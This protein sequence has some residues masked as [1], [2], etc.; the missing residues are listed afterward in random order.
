MSVI[1]PQSLRGKAGGD[2]RSQPEHTTSPPLISAP[3]SPDSQRS[4]AV[5]LRL[6][7]G[8]S[9]SPWRKQKKRHRRWD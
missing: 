2:F 5:W 1:S 3:C 8:V 4:V 6:F 7:W 9:P